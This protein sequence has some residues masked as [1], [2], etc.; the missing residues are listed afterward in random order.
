MTSSEEDNRAKVEWLIKT[1]THAEDTELGESARQQIYSQPDLALFPAASI[2]INE[3]VDDDERYT[4]YGLIGTMLLRSGETYIAEY[5]IDQIA[6]EPK[7]KLRE[8]LLENIASGARRGA[9]ATNAENVLQHAQEGEKMPSLR[10]EAIQALGACGGDPQAEVLLLEILTQLKE[11]GWVLYEAIEALS[12]V[13]TD[14]AQPVMLQLLDRIDMLPIKQRKKEIKNL[15]VKILVEVGGVQ[16]SDLCVKLLEDRNA[17]T[18]RQAMRGLAR[19][20]QHKDMMAIKKRVIKILGTQRK[21][22][23][24]EGPY[25]CPKISDILHCL[26]EHDESDLTE[27][28]FGIE[29]LSRFDALTSDQRLLKMLAD[30][31][32]ILTENEKELLRIKAPESVPL[33]AVL[34]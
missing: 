16:H 34:Q 5:L 23:Q 4:A 24:T 2:Y 1:W 3:L 18:K 11:S 7:K 29:A 13:A 17:G 10:Q 22:P 25:L 30:K 32:D 27:L 15:A 8:Y 31:W 6:R 9:S 20:A 12:Y 21:L 14:N 33:N 28:F 26:S 19:F